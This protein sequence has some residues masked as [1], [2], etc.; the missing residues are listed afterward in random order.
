M[1]S[2]SAVAEGIACGGKLRVVVVVVKAKGRD[3]TATRNSAD[4]KAKWSSTAD[5][6]PLTAD[7]RPVGGRRSMVAETSPI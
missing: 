6:R 1:D 3:H 4:E 7:G 5:R 2:G